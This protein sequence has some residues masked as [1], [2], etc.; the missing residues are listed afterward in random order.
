MAVEVSGYWRRYYLLKYVEM[1]NVYN[2]GNMVVCTIVR[3]FSGLGSFPGTASGFKKKPANSNQ[4]LV[5]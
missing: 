1:I 5:E 3:R 4:F 2:K